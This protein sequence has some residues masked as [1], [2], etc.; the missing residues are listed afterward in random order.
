MARDAV[1]AT[2]GNGATEPEQAPRGHLYPGPVNEP[3]TGTASRIGS[4]ARQVFVAVR[5]VRA[6][7]IGLLGRGARFV[8]AG[9]VVAVIYLATTTVLANVFG[10]PFQLALVIGFATALIVHFSLQR[11][12][13]WAHNEEFS[14]P[15]HEQI[16]RYLLVAATQYGTTAAVTA[17]LPSALHISTTIV[18]F[19][20]ATGIAASNFVIFRHGI[21]HANPPSDLEAS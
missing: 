8:I 7:D 1:T 3:E 11:F 5:H 14:L 12:F 10:V 20:W 17:F 18:F 6:R 4:A 15:V 9:G 13:V 2:G 16:G 19:V 21:F